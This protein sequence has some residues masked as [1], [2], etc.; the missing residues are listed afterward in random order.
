[1]T[2]NFKLQRPHLDIRVALLPILRCLEPFMN[3]VD[4]FI[5]W[6]INSTFMSL[7]LL[8]YPN[9]SLLY[10]I[11]HAMPRKEPCRYLH[12]SCYYEHTHPKVNC[13]PSSLANPMHMLST[14]LLWC[15][16]F[17]LIDHLFKGEGSYS[18]LYPLL[19]KISAIT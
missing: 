3:G 5:V 6:S 8:P 19:L 11:N 18:N 13:G 9:R 10:Y 7:L 2:S 15:E 16:W 17:F 4:H 1:M 14:Y 12:G